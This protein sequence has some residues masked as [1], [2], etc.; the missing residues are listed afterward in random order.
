LLAV[1]GFV[2][3]ELPTLAALAPFLEE[4]AALEINTHGSILPFEHQRRINNILCLGSNSLWKNAPYGRVKTIATCI[5][6]DERDQQWGIREA[7]I[8]NHWD[9][10]EREWV[11]T[12]RVT[13]YENPDT[14]YFAPPK[15]K[16]RSKKA[17]T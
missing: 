3:T 12:R 10:P 15:R 13:P 11:I 4:L 14:P 6:V 7:N 8:V 5:A 9:T 16:R 2:P 17:T 1:L